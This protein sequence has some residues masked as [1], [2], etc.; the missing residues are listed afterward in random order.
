VSTIL[1]TVCFVCACSFRPTDS[2]TIQE[3]CIGEVSRR[4]RQ[5][6]EKKYLHTLDGQTVRLQDFFNQCRDSAPDCV[7]FAKFYHWENKVVQVVSRSD[8]GP[9]EHQVRAYY[10]PLSI[11]RPHKIQPG[12]THGD[13]AEFYDPRGRFMGLA[14]YMG[15]GQ[16]FLLYY[17]EYQN[18]KIDQK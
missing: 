17:S 12:R 16:Y 14:V 11:C 15:Q 13:V 8:S 9:V 2:Q 1:L 6:P 4:I 3:D 10:N 18:P 7:L 5:A